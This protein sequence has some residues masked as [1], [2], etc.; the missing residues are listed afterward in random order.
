MALRLF[1]YG[2]SSRKQRSEDEPRPFRG[3]RLGAPRAKFGKE[4]PCEG[5]G[6]GAREAGS[7]GL[8]RTMSGFWR[9]GPKRWL[10]DEVAD[11]VVRVM[12]C[13]AGSVVWSE[14]DAGRVRLRE[15]RGTR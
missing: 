13:P 6:L 10:L 5:S 7:T 14:R 12:N 11:V 9:Q 15:R 8:A 3:A 2:D 4:V 1:Y